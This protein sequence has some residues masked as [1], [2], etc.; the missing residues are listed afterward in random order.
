MLYYVILCIIQ[1]A[2][3]AD[4]FAIIAAGPGADPARRAMMRSR[5]RLVMHIMLY[6]NIILYYTTLHYIALC[7]IVLYHIIFFTGCSW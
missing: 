4:R 1:A 7:C 2:A 6:Y 5:L 3:F